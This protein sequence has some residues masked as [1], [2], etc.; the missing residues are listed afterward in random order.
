[1]LMEVAVEHSLEIDVLDITHTHNRLEVEYGERIPVITIPEADTELA[2]P[3][4]SN[5]IRA[6]LNL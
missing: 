5:D 2:W 1:M 3:F 4:T 6:Y